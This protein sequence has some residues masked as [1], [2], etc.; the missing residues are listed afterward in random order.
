MNV[1]ET[2][3][4]KNAAYTMG[5]ATIRTTLSTADDVGGVSGVDDEHMEVSL[6]L[7]F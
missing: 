7:A 6:V 4:A 1:T 2:T 3:K 5:A